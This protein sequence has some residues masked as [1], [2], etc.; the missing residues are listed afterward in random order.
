MGAAAFVAHNVA[1]LPGLI[2]LF[3]IMS[4]IFGRSAFQ[5]LDDRLFK[6]WHVGPDDGW[7]WE[8]VVW[9]CLF[10]S[11]FHVLAQPL[12]AAVHVAL[13]VAYKRL[14]LGALPP[15]ARGWLQVAV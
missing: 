7:H 13:T 8:V 11:L 3:A 4:G 12:G 2:A 14:V 9:P 6:A 15:G 5:V 1:L 10:V